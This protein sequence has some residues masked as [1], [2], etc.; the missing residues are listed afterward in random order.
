MDLFELL[1][2]NLEINLTANDIGFAMLLTIIA[3]LSTG[4]GSIIAYF[5]KKPKLSYLSLLLSLSAGVML[6]VSF[7]ELLNTAVIDVGFA[8]A[9][10]FFFIGIGIILLIDL[11][12][13]HAYAQETGCDLPQLIEDEGKEC[14]ICPED[15]NCL[16]RTGLFVAL[17]IAIHNFPEGLATF[18]SG[19]SGDVSLAITIAFAIALHNIPEGISVS[20]PIFYATGNKKKGMLYSLLSGLS[21]PVGALIGLIILLPFLNILLLSSVLAAVAGI[22]VYISLDELLPNAHKFGKGK[23]HLVL[24]G[25]LA[26]MAIMAISLLVLP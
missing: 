17:G 19:I 26:G 2:S 1:T 16:M 12:V 6:Y 23:E 25:L 14:L 15:R 5:I 3:G 21:E 9:N 24:G 13:P 10:F 22:M 11:I 20:I 4:I 7:I 18:S 8:C